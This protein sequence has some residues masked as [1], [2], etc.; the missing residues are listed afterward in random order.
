MTGVNPIKYKI[1]LEPDL[2]NFRFAGSTEILLDVVRPV[3]ETILNI[4]ELA[5]WNCKV[6]VGDSFVDCPFYVNPGK[7]EMTIS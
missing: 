6:R 5:I 4:L 2:K 7:E 1:H 3:S